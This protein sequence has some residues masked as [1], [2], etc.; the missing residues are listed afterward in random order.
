V[1]QI[2]KWRRHCL[3]HAW[4]LKEAPGHLHAHVPFPKMEV[5]L[6]VSAIKR[7]GLLELFVLGVFVSGLPL[8][9]VSHFGMQGSEEHR[10]NSCNFWKVV[11]PAFL[12]AALPV[13]CYM[14]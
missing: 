4:S 7:T 13:S 11:T 14:A 9:S 10:A 6:S 1:F 2:E 5:F 12:L 8:V 3:L